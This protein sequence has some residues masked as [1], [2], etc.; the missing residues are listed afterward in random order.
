MNPL[1]HLLVLCLIAITLCYVLR[2]IFSPWKTC[3]RCHGD[4]RRY[5]WKCDG[6]GKRVRNT[7]RI[8]AFLLRSWKD[9]K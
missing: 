5:C 8:A 9:S 6:T 7:Y 2:R 4:R 1:A 3:P